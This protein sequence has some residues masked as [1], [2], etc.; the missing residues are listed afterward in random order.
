MLFK[1]WVTSE[2]TADGWTLS[3]IGAGVDMEGKE[4]DSHSFSVRRKIGDASYDC[5]GSVKQAAHVE[6]NIKLCQ[7][8][9]AA[10]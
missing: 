3:W 6:K 5:Y 8:L 1:K 2:K 9:K 4:Y 10:Q 7:G